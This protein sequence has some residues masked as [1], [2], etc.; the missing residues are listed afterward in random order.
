MKTKIE[1]LQIIFAD[2]KYESKITKVKSTHEYITKVYNQFLN[3]PNETAF[4]ARLFK[5]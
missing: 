1:M 2:T 3:I 5:I 4:Y